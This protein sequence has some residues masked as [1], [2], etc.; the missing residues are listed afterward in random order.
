VA[1]PSS[2]P[3]P[4]AIHFRMPSTFQYLNPHTFLFVAGAVATQP[5]GRDRG[6]N[7]PRISAYLFAT[8]S[9]DH[10]GTSSTTVVPRRNRLS[11]NMLR[12]FDSNGPTFTRE[13]L[14]LRA[15]AWSDPVGTKRFSTVRLKS[16]AMVSGI[17]RLD[18]KMN[19]QFPFFR[20]ADGQLTRI[21]GR[22][23]RL[24]GHES[25]GNKF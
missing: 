24:D 5:T 8:H 14:H 25:R 2:R 10:D 21:S 1:D 3:P 18:G 13:S 19:L 9:F 17:M 11:T 22:L 20:S 23:N 16:Y 15:N 6:P 7:M 12:T 4:P